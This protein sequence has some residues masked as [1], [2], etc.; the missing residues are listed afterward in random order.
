MLKDSALEK[1][2][3]ITEEPKDTALGMEK[4]R[5][6]N[7]VAPQ[8]PSSPSR[9]C[10]HQWRD[11]HGFGQGLNWALWEPGQKTKW[12]TLIDASSITAA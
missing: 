7:P 6:S 5:V 3:L 8:P 9:S 11:S 1:S 4:G 2:C 12:P 10:W